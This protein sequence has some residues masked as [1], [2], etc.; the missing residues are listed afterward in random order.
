MMAMWNYFINAL[1]TIL[2]FQTLEIKP[3]I[4]KISNQPI[5]HDQL[6]SDI[7]HLPVLLWHGLGD[8]Y[9]SES[10]HWVADQFLKVH[11]NLEIYSIYVDENSSKDKEASIFGDLMTQVNEVCDQVQGLDFD[12][13][14]GFNAVGFS[15][16]GLF[17]RSL[18]EICDI[19]INNLISVGSP[20]NGFVDL[21]P[22]D[23]SS[24]L[25]KRKNAFLKNR[26]YTDYMQNNN[27]QAQYFRDVNDYE[28]YLEKSAFLKFVNNDL[29]KNLDYYNRMIQ[30]NKFVMVI[31]EKDETL[32]PKETAWFYD[33]DSVT[34]DL[35]PFEETES[36]IFDF[37]G[38]KRLN[39]QGKIDFLK[40]DDLHLKMS[41]DDLM[42][43]AKNY[44]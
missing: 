34:G 1:L 24:Y 22:C 17:L 33:V 2:N 14:K 23:P 39:E 41:E 8:S 43:L 44:L 32:V 28:K 27:I 5:T 15:Q 3:T 10:M 9:D 19:K 37:I 20:Q 21:P 11:P 12:G 29:F 26:F 4:S 31:F 42:G 18:V 16:G 25:C 36:Y 38:L 6:S 7:Q 35:I 30:L 40:I 13:T